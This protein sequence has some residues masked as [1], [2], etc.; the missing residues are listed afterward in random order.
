[1]SARGGFDS[2]RKLL[3]APFGPDGSHAFDETVGQRLLSIALSRGG[4]Y[5]DLFFEYRAAGG[6]SQSP[7]RSL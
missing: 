7:A 4:D 2:A 5:A 6:I 1:M 3:L